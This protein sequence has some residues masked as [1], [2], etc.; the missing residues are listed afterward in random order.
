M[1][2]EISQKNIWKLEFPY[3][4]GNG[5]FPG[6]EDNEAVYAEFYLQDDI[7]NVSLA[8]FF[9]ELAAQAT[10]PFAKN[11]LTSIAKKLISL[12]ADIADY[13]EQEGMTVGGQWEL[14]GNMIT[15]VFRF[16]FTGRE[17]ETRLIFTRIPSTVLTVT[18]D[19]SIVERERASNENGNLQTDEEG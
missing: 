3:Y 6:V 16:K 8:A 13:L 19:P 10:Y 18:G 7:N 14:N 5:F 2:V 9:N 12:S 11:Q 4:T 15:G 1:S 17:V